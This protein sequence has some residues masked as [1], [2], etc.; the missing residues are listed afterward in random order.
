MK[1]FRS[2][3]SFF[4]VAGILGVSLENSTGMVVTED[5]VD[6]EVHEDLVGQQDTE[7]ADLVVP[8]DLEVLEDIDPVLN[9]ISHALLRIEQTCTWL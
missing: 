6:T 2:L 7:W 4:L 3:G 9:C 1:E 8:A 5:M